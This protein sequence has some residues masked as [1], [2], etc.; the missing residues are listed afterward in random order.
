VVNTATVSSPTDDPH[1]P[2]N[3]ADDSTGVS[4]QADL[5]IVKS[6]TGTATAGED[7]AFTL[8]VTNHG[9]SDSPAPITVS[10]SL[11]P[12]MTYVSASGGW[13]CSATGRVVTCT[14]ASALPAN[15][16]STITLNVHLS[17]DAGPAFLLN[18]ASVDGTIVD[19]NPDNNTDFDIVAVRD[20]ANVRITKSAS[21][22]DA[23]AGGPVT[24]TLTVVN[25]G[26]SDADNVQVSDALP[27]GMEYVGIDSD[28]GVTCADANPID[29]Q[30]STMPAARRSRFAHG[31]APA[32][33]RRPG[34]R[35]SRP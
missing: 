26:P 7:L 24:Y 4:L 1:L 9:S 12:G 10:D 17:P 25:D 20:R 23:V 22:T 6:H 3:T 2:N 14:F 34:S 31:S 33:L 15:D 28:P 18:W 11:P 32:S 13:N 8:E 19:P 29:C 16:S 21:P 5:G 30:L 35:T 27:P